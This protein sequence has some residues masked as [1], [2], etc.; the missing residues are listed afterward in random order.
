MIIGVTGDSDI[1]TGVNEVLNSLYD[2]GFVASFVEQFYDD[3]RIEM[4]LVLMCRDPMLHFKQRIRFSKN[5]NC[6]Y[7]DIM[8]DWNKMVGAEISSRKKIVGEKIV[9]EVPQIVA[10]KKFRDFDLLRFTKDLRDWFETHGWIEP[11]FAEEI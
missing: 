8:L 7:M 4:F 9:N 10:K 3:S 6:L 1:E 2:E 5:D 11:D